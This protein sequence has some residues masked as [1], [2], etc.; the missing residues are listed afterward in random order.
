MPPVFTF[1]RRGK[2][3]NLLVDKTVLK[4]RGAEVYE[5][6]RGGDVTWHGPGQLVLYPVLDL[7]QR[8]LMVGDLVRGIE[9]SVIRCLREFGIDA[10]PSSEFIGLWVAGRKIASIGL[11]VTKSISYHGVALNV[12]PD[13]SYFD[14]I[15]PCGIKGVTMTSMERV[16]GGSRPWRRSRKAL[17]RRGIGIRSRIGRA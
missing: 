9:R 13:L 11:A 2:K 12:S 16:L 5:V 1:G 4:K 6:E 8:K 14:L 15:N 10:E 17:R 3:E 7:K